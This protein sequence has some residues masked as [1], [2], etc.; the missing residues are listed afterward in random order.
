MAALPEPPADSRP[1]YWDFWRHDLWTRAQADDPANF[2]HWPC[3]RHTMTVE[4]FPVSE[5]LADLQSHRWLPVIQ[6]AHPHHARNLIHQAYHLKRWED[7]TGRLVEDLDTIY[8]FGAG[9]GAMA[10]LARR[11]GFHGRYF[12]NDLPEF[13]L[14][15]RYFLGERGIA[16]EH[17][18]SL[19][20]YNPDLFIGLYSVSETPANVR[21]EIT[22]LVWAKSYLLIYSGQWAEHD[23]H[24]WAR[25]FMQFHGDLTWRQTQFPG[26][27]DWYA[28]GWQR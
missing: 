13:V 21:Q 22:H 20:D 18:E 10:D 1:P 9:Y 7:A 5:Q 19:R 15:Q 17:V 16:V 6:D 28:I 8:E 11:L 3:V 12:I 2:W 26:R 4:H 14:L 27:P 23:N 24:A 25:E